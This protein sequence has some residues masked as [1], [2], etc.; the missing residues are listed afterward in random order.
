MSGRHFGKW[1]LRH[2]CA[3]PDTPIG[4]LARGIMDAQDFGYKDC[5]LSKLP[6]GES[7]SELVATIFD[8][9]R[10]AL[11]LV[12]EAV[13]KFNSQASA[14]ERKM[15]DGVMDDLNKQVREIVDGGDE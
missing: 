5:D 1:L 13:A 3:Y 8:G 4:S 7:V 14:R 9:D 10:Y 15:L 6:T 12:K 2:H 11:D